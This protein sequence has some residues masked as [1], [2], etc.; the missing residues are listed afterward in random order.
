MKMARNPVLILSIW[1]MFA[2]TVLAAGP[3][4]KWRIAV[5][6]SAKV[7]GEIELS[8]TPK[9]GAATSLVVPIPAGAHENQAARLIRDA[10]RGKYGKSVYKTELDDGEDVLVKV[11][12]STP[13]VEIVVVRNTAEGL[14]L[15]LSRE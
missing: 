5:N 14:S 2:V 6:H 3:S 12:G 7:A 1:L 13:D 10:I 8:F 9:G 15:H 11:R 4:N